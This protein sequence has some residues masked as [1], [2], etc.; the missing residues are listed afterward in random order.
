MTSLWQRTGTCA[1][2]VLLGLYANSGSAQ[3]LPT[4][5]QHKEHQPS[6]PPTQSS[7]CHH[8]L[9]MVGDDTMARMAALDAR[10]DMLVSDVQMLAGELK[11]AAMT[12][13]MTAMVERDKVMRGAMMQMHEQMMNRMNS[14]APAASGHESCMMCSMMKHKT[15]DPAP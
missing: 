11:I 12:S 14:A 13:L 3:T 7:G 8:A 1:L 2:A 4:A 6:A 10:I 5:D 15:G 9:K